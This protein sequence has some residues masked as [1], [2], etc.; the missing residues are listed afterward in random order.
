MKRAC[1]GLGL[2]GLV[3]PAVASA[4]TLRVGPGA[5]YTTIEAAVDASSSGDRIE[6]A[7]GSYT[8]A[9]TIDITHDL[10]LVGAVGAVVHGAT[11]LLN[12]S[13]ATVVVESLELRPAVSAHAIYILR[14]SAVTLT[15]LTVTPEPGAAVG[16][17]NGR[18][19]VAIG[20]DIDLDIL[21]GS[22]VGLR[23]TVAAGAM[24][25]QGN[26]VTLRLTD[27]EFTDCAGASGGAV[28]VQ[29]G[30]SLEV[31]GSTFTDND[32]TST[33]G[34]AIFV[35]S[36]GS[37]SIAE[38]TFT[39]TACSMAAWIVH[40]PSPLSATRPENCSSDWSLTSAACF[41]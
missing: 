15:D 37:V 23:T 6:I 5:T 39:G 38:S 19:V 18:A 22:F 34:G 7:A 11:D 2:I 40:R 25:V 28:Y 30:A 24:I 35:D 8:L 9:D 33:A 12:I 36:I 16:S 26:G 20:P 32:A 31:L 14:D 27:V 17:Q 10:T 21:G 13:G 1:M 4:T 41:A 3:T 29:A